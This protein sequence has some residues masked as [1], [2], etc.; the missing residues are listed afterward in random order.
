MNRAAVSSEVR[1]LTLIQLFLSV[2]SPLKPTTQNPTKDGQGKDGMSYRKTSISYGQSAA[3][4]YGLSSPTSTRAGNRRRDTGDAF[5]LQANSLASPTG[6][7]RFPKDDA[8]GPTPPSAGLIRRRTDVRD[9]ESSSGVDERDRDRKIST[10]S[11]PHGTLKRGTSSGNVGTM[12]SP[13]GGSGFTS[14]GSFGSF[15]LGAGSSQPASEKRPPVGSLRGESRFKGLM[16]KENAEEGSMGIKEHPS[17]SHLRRLADPSLEYE[18][19]SDG[20]L[21]FRQRNKDIDQYQEEERAGSAALGGADDASP[22]RPRGFGTPSRGTEDE[23]FGAFGMTSDT[24]GGFPGMQ[25]KDNPHQQ[26]PQGR[27]EGAQEQMSPTDTNPYQSPENDKPDVEIDD[28]QNA[29]LPGLGGYGMDQGSVPRFGGFAAARP[30][31]PFDLPGGDRSQNSST[32]PSRGFPTLGGL[33]GLSG[34]GSS[35]LWAS[36][37]GTIGTPTRERPAFGTGFGDGVF[38][39]GAES[40][41]PALAGLGST[42]VFGAAA[43]PDISGMS[44]IGRSSKIGSLL[45]PAM[46]E[47]MRQQAEPAR[48]SLDEAQFDAFDRA[49]AAAMFNNSARTAFGTGAIGSQA[50]TRDNEAMLRR[51][52]FESGFPQHSASSI[53]EPSAAL[54]P[55]LSAAAAGA[56]SGAQPVIHRQPS[57][58]ASPSS[59]QPPVAQQRTMVMPDRMRWIY[60][61]PTGNVQGPWTG[62][63]MHDWYKAGFFTPELLIKKVEDTEYEPLAQLIR[64]IGNSREPFLVPQVGVPHDVPASQRSWVSPAPGGPPFAGSF[65]SFGTTLTAEQQNALERRKQ[66][67]QYLMA[68]QKEH[69]AQQQHFQKQIAQQQVQQFGLP[70]MMP[71]QVHHQ[72]SAHSL[73]SQPSFGSMTSPAAYQPSPTQ[74]PLPGGPP[75]PPFF[76]GPF[77][78]PP[79]GG[80]GHGG[81]AFELLAHLREDE[82]PGA[83]QRLALVPSIPSLAGPA[84]PMGQQPMDSHHA[85][86][87]HQMIADRMRLMQEQ[88]EHDTGMGPDDGAQISAER[89]Q[90]FQDF[91]NARAAQEETDEDDVDDTEVDIAARPPQ[92]IPELLRHEDPVEA[93]LNHSKHPEPATLTE[94]VQKSQSAKQAAQQTVWQKLDVNTMQPL[95]PPP[96][97]ESPMPAPVAQRKQNVA[98]TLAAESQSRTQSPIIDTPSSSIAPWAN[99]PAEAPRGPSLR[100]IQEAEAKKA[101]QVELIAAQARREAME[102]ELAAQAAAAQPLPGLPSTSTWGSG[103][104]PA[105]ATSASVWSKPSATKAQAN[106]GN[107]PKKTLQQIQKEEEARKQR[108]AAAAAAAAATTST[109]SGNPAATS[110]QSGPTGKRYAD[111]AGKSITTPPSSASSAWQTVGSSGK[112]KAPPIPPTQ[113]TTTRAVSGA[114]TSTAPVAKPKPVQRSSTMGA[115]QLSK[116]E[117]LNSFKEWAV[118]DLRPHLKKG[119][120]G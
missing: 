14:M 90:Q 30:T 52:G 88:A 76:D 68:R 4:P 15:A 32:G 94:Q 45:S 75:V 61:D 80:L 106:S 17:A 5:S 48:R 92:Q 3:S 81:S 60:K 58:V 7:S 1:L 59:E 97:S 102:K 118:T 12:W 65:P 77:R 23:V 47:Q 105:S 64:R 99:Q 70:P 22:P 41:M 2:N 117:A 11:Q 37:A 101:A 86:Q 78:G 85:Q 19:A 35:S 115:A 62:L 56:G 6:P 67:E 27:Q 53:S 50:P 79:P 116:V 91:R 13:S 98:D 84:G 8:A 40:Q 34:L 20:S 71:Q 72:S 57:N 21:A 110:T 43:G 100:E 9:S 119:T 18:Q 89:L 46:Q 112:A 73:H 28:D 103:Q 49:Q 39:T 33:G 111:L 26:T 114:V 109:A 95:I 104:S 63:E 120:N 38:T 54:A 87:V 31:A 36:G 108:A 96:K 24:I 66:E 42:N 82:L 69:L 16:S 107:G 10:D 55:G 93:P 29:P 25:H 83:L 44:S 51:A 113:P 74:A